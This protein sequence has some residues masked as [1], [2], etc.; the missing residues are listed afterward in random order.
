[1]WLLYGH[2]YDEQHAGITVHFTG[3]PL[4][5]PEQTTTD[6]YGNIYWPVDIIAPGTIYANCNDCQEVPAP[7]TWVSV[8][9]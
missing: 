7:E 3:G 6:N 8:G 4:A 1:V 2:V 9:F 5:Q